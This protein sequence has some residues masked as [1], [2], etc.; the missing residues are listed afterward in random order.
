M[1]A[2]KREILLEWTYATNV[3]PFT[4]EELDLLSHYAKNPENKESHIYLD[5]YKINIVSEFK[6]LF[7]KSW[8]LSID[9]ASGLSQDSSA[10][11]L[12]DPL[13]YKPVMIFNSN[14]IG[15][16][17]FADFIE[18]FVL[19]YVPNAVV[20]PERNNNGI[21]FLE[22]LLKSNISSNL[23]YE[24][25]NVS[26]ETKVEK[27][28]MYKNRGIKSKTKTFVYGFNT[29]GTSRLKLFENL[30]VIINERPDLI[31]NEYLFDEIRTL[32]RKKTGK[33]EHSSSSHDDTLMAFLIGY[34][35]LVDNV[36]INK[37][38]KVVGDETSLSEE[39]RKKGNKLKSIYDLYKNEEN[40]LS[41]EL[42]KEFY[43]RDLP[44]E[45]LEKYNKENNV[46]VEENKNSIFE[47]NEKLN[48]NKKINS[49]IQLNNRQNNF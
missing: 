43:A 12:I 18:K 20:I 36:N 1:L 29:T 14:K 17:E 37:F 31:N 38:I 19:T 33:I 7:Y 41:E 23:F 2:V 16:I 22:R 5:D 35:T 40:T 28:A 26:I 48:K 27:K 4:E 30:R 10:F 47:R 34:T 15:V 21:P 44:L 39:N 3:S 25:K 8:V 13:T 11:T 46:D 24:E 49:I 32:E 9:I 45:L 6:N 42:I